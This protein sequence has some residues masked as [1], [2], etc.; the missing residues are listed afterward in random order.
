MI[1][2]YEWTTGRYTSTAICTHAYSFEPEHNSN[3]L[4]CFIFNCW[5]EQSYY[6]TLHEQKKILKIPTCACKT[7]GRMGYLLETGK[8]V[9]RSNTARAELTWANIIVLF[10]YCPI[11]SV[12]HLCKSKTAHRT[13]AKNLNKFYFI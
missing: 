13:F 10:L 4:C 7:N 2:R 3:W 9:V 6:I 1:W 8:S 5:L 12:Y 11:I